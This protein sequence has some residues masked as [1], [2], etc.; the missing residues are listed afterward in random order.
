MRA[1]E[2]DETITLV[3]V[4]AHIDWRD[5]VNGV[6]EGYTSPIRRA[7]EMGWFG[8]I[9]QIGIRA[10]G[11]AREEEVNDARVYGADNITAYEMHEKGM[12]A[13]L[14]RINNKILLIQTDVK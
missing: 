5:E 6:R 3:H 2:R 9:V 8:H 10:N 11:S 12:S 14:N 13:V 4:D 7:S 1:L